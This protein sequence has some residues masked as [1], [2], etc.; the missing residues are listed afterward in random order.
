MSRRLREKSHAGDPR[1]GR[2]R[3]PDWPACSGFRGSCSCSPGNS[4]PA[5]SAVVRSGRAADRAGPAGHH[6]RPPLRGRL[7]GLV[8]LPARRAQRTGRAALRPPDT[9]S[10]A[11]LPGLAATQRLA[12]G[13]LVS[14]IAMVSTAQAELGGATAERP[15][16]DP[17]SPPVVGGQ[18]RRRSCTRCRA[19]TAD[20]GRHRP[21]HPRAAT[22][23]DAEGGRRRTCTS[24][25]AVTTCGRW[26]SATTAGQD[27]RR[28]AAANPTD[29]PAGP[30][31][32]RS[33]WKLRIPGV[34]TR[35]R[36]A[37]EARADRRSDARPATKAASNG[38][39]AAWRHP[40]GHRRA[41][42]RGGTTLAGAVAG[43]PLPAGR[44]RRTADR[45]APRRPDRERRTARDEA[46]P[47]RHTGH[48]PSA[49][50]EA[51]GRDRAATRHQHRAAAVPTVEVDRGSGLGA[52][53]ATTRPTTSAPAAPSATTDAEATATRGQRSTG[54]RP[55]AD[56]STASRGRRLSGRRAGLAAAGALLS[57]S[58]IAGLA[59]RRRLQLQARPLGRRILHP[60]VAG[61][62]PRWCSATGPGRWACARWIWPP[63]RSA[64]LPPRRESAARA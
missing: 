21:R 9:P 13:L 19:A 7:G 53:E 50:P 26:L 33:G 17:I 22:R 34:E 59:A 29:S 35:L 12:A 18:P 11:R 31:G 6:D 24:S 55:G 44:S 10:A 28:I 60:A 64:P 14:V 20:G 58:L 25:N 56:S 51:P 1:P 8:D 48:G 32:W 40:V 30:T 43:Q 5:L 39:R 38:G 42:L 62:P 46:S 61:A 57:A 16:P 2:A 27:W 63:G 15:R 47:S 45:H 49:E 4:G 3:R 37:S 23:R 41:R 54:T 36:R 52:A